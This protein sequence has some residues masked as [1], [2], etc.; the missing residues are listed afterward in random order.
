MRRQICLLALV[1]S[2]SLSSAISEHSV[3][4]DC[5]V[6]ITITS[7]PFALVSSDGP[8]VATLSA[9]VQNSGST[10]LKNVTVFLGNGT[11]PG[12]FDD[13]GGQGLQMLGS[14]S[15]ATRFLGNLS[16]GAT[17]TLYWHVV[18]PS[19]TDISY[20]YTVWA[21]SESSC[22]A[23]Q[24]ATL[25]TRSASALSSSKILPTDG[26]VTLEPSSGQIGV[27]QLV[28]VTI[29]G[30]DL[31]AVGA[32]PEAVEDVWLQPVSNPSFDPS[33]LRLVRTEAA[34]NS[35]RATPYS[36]Q[37]Y[38]TGIGSHNPPPNYARNPSDYVKYTFIG[39]RNCSTTLQPYQQAASGSGHKFNTDIGAITLNIHVRD[40]LGRLSLDTSVTPTAATP[41]TTLTYS[42]AYGNTGGAPAGDPASGSS[43]VITNILPSEITY[44]AGSSTCSASCLKLWSTD[45]GATFVTTEP[46]PAASV[47][48]LQWVILEP[49]PAGQNPAGTVGFQ[50]TAT[51][52][53][54]VC[55]TA[56]GAF[57]SASVVASDTACANSATDIE[58]ALSGPTTVLPGASLNL[59][60]SYHNAGP[61]V[62]EDV[63]IA[64]TLPDGTQFV[65]A[66]S[67]PT[68]TSGQLV[69]FL[70]GSLAPGQGGSVSV[71]VAVLSSVPTGTTLTTIAQATTD[72][73]ETN[74]ANNS[75]SL[76]TTVGTATHSPQ[77]QAILTAT[78]VED[79][80]PLGASPGDTL[81]YSATITNAG[82]S[83]ATGV[84]FRF[85]QD[86]H[87][88]LVENSVVA[89]TGTIASGNAPGDS[90]VRVDLAT[91]APGA[92]ATVQVRVRIKSPLP[93]GTVSIRAQGLVSSNERP[94]EPT[95][96]PTTPTPFDP[97][98]TFVSTTPLLRVQKR[99]AIFNDL[100]GN[101]LP[102]PGDILKYTITV[103]NVGRENAGSVVLSDGLDPNVT[104]VIGSVTTTQGAVLFGNAENDRFVQV[105]LG[106]LAGNSESV[107]ITFRVGV[108]TSLPGGVTT[109][110]N[111]ALV[112]SENVPSFPSDDPTTPA[113]DDPTFTV[114]TEQPYV[115]VSMRDFLKLDADGDGLPSPGDT[116]SYHITL[117]NI[118]NADATNVF[119]SD[120]PDLNSALIVGSVRTSVGT[121]QTGNTVGDSSV[122]VLIDRIPRAGG[123]ASVSFDVTVKDSLPSSVV[124]L[125]NQALVNVPGVG[126]T[127]SDDPDTPALA[128]AT[129]TAIAAAP[130]M[131]FTKDVFLVYDTDHSGTISPGDI[132][133]YALTLINAGTRDAT[134]ILFSDTPDPNTRVVGGSTS[135]AL[136]GNLGI[137]GAFGGQKRTS[138][139]VYINN[140]L[141]PDAL[142]ISNQAQIS[143]A[144]IAA[145]YSD[146]PRTP[147][148]ND[149][150]VVALGSSFLLC[151]DVDSNGLVE[152]ADA[153]V[154]ARAILGA[155]RLTESQ[156]LAADVAPP[157]GVLDARDVTLISEIARGYRAYCPPL[158]ARNP[159]VTILQSRASV[160]LER[161]WHQAQG[162]AIRF[163]AQGVGIAEM[164]VQVFNLAGKAVF[165]SEWQKGTE[166]HWLALS[167]EGRP[168]ANGVY[169]YVLN[170]RG[171]DGSLVRSRIHKLVILR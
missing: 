125:A 129:K 74:T 36:D 156:R 54:T 140:P 91:L 49:V 118:G 20:P 46:S 164:S 138:F 58:L 43:L 28:T 94:D 93:Y 114:V 171:A 40:T 108:N 8:R 111:H 50:A 80:P 55:T 86:P 37:I 35:I 71:Q 95:D 57:G 78:L 75:A 63:Q 122:G 90:Q 67:A 168:L 70:I 81:E 137:I 123:I 47:T 105:N 15:E 101:G 73:S 151:G 30:F 103:T 31:G 1:L 153:Q 6:V 162:R 11:T 131:H 29:T 17:R 143:G 130:L 42:I 124:S 83:P 5:P 128:D 136:T 64:L 84:V 116:L 10:A 154:V 68:S 145:Q 159:A 32:G 65:S 99:Y 21:T 149:A 23:A 60:I 112:S 139:R 76:T 106:T 96:D 33:C 24:S 44:V 26:S 38:F 109:V 59:I 25:Q 77:L 14:S 120:T 72:S 66:S 102:S 160:T 16:A 169:L 100:D 61:S 113:V 79:A 19:T 141:P 161:V 97:T 87:T 69:T 92:S 135:S 163:R 27:G 51:S 158:D 117:I 150:T 62:A 170:V 155:V 4:A 166:L 167:A 127:A 53:D 107:T 56:Q 119:L 132:I 9:K 147:T 82:P 148:P 48:A 121:V 133:E 110:S 22:S 34:L 142:T 165:V 152:E 98:E 39:L 157:F 104:L 146:D 3:Y 88:D 7:S 13:A 2:I 45:G 12:V 144:N 89:T 41:G 52:A 85:T 18:Y 134:D 115:L 126:S